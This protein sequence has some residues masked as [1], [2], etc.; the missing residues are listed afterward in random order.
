I[1]LITLKTDFGIVI[2]AFR[3]F[4]QPTNKLVKS[5]PLRMGR[6]TKSFDVP[7]IDQKGPVSVLLQD[8]GN[9]S[10]RVKQTGSSD[11][12]TVFESFNTSLACHIA[13]Y[14]S[15][16]GM[17]TGQQ[18]SSGWRTDTGTGISV[19]KPNALSG[20]L[21][22]MRCPNNLVSVASQ[23]AISQIVGDDQYDIGFSDFL[24]LHIEK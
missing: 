16:P 22:Q 8:M 2:V 1:G 12:N 3:F 10:I 20:Q 5:F 14:S 9:G 15:M 7:F 17:F 23:V 4:D 13:P 6:F 21:I 11:R 24:C 18:C 19:C